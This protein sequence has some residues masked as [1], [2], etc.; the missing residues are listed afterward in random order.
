MK[1]VCHTQSSRKL[2]TGLC[3]CVGGG[4]DW[5]GGYSSPCR[6]MTAV[7]WHTL[8]EL[9]SQTDFYLGGLQRHM[10]LETKWLSISQLVLSFCV[11]M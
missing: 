7:G 8:N 3:V 11:V 4:G 9:I 10:C 6:G 1:F 5:V 2:N